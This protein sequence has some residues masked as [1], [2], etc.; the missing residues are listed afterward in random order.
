MATKT[1]APTHTIET[2]HASPTGQPAVKA[3]CGCSVCGNT[4]IIIRADYAAQQGLA[5]ATKTA[6]THVHNLVRMALSPLAN[7]PQMR[8]NGPWKA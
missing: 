2:G 5:K 7:A 4:A 1:T 3:T 6:H 8:A